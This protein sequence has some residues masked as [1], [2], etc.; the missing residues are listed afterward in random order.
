[1]AHFSKVLDVLV[2][3]RNNDVAC[4]YACIV[5]RQSIHDASYNAQ[6]RIFAGLLSD[7]SV[8]IAKGNAKE[9]AFGASALYE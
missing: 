2:G 5:S 8:A 4:L 6:R 9:A 3:N 1:M 7:C